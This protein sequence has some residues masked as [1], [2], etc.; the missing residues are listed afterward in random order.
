[1]TRTRTARHEMVCKKSV[2]KVIQYSL[3]PNMFYQRDGE[4]MKGAKD[5][6][7]IDQEESQ[8]TTL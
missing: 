8:N 6:E 4:A 3:G 1:M 5:L 2:R 7:V